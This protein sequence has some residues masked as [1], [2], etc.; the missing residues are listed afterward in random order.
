[1]EPSVP[2][3]KPTSKPASTKK[4]ASMARA[5]RK[6]AARERLSLTEAM[7]ALEAAGSA[8]TRKTYA[9][10]GAQEPMFGVS[11]ATLKALV[12][13]IGMD[14]ELACKLWETGNYDARNLAMKIADPQRMSAKDLDDWAQVGAH[15]RMCGAYVPMLA[16]EGPLA[17]AKLEEWMESENQALGGA[18]WV[19]LSQLLSRDESLGDEEA[20][21]WL[22]KIEKTI[23]SAPNLQRDAMNSAL[24]HIGCRSAGLRKS[25][26]AAARRIGKVEVDHGDTACKTPDAGQSIEKA[27]EHSLSKGFESPAAHER[28]R[29]LPRLRC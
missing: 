16:A 18:A 21:S 7:A 28:S 5:P 12:K 20:L 25:A 4:P 8:Q 24:I 6:K 27:W 10:H 11:F 2:A 29:E 9:R 22:D 3:K 17:R 19:L 26:L 23:H 14:H 13:R 1:M 15:T